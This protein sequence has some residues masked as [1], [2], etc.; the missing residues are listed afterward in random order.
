MRQR[1]GSH[2]PFIQRWLHPAWVPPLTHGFS[3]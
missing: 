3:Q 2:F 1:K